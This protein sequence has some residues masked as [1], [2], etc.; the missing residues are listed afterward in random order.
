M[1]WPCLLHPGNSIGDRGALALISA[2]EGGTNGTANTELTTL[3]IAQ[4]N[5]LTQKAEDELRTRR[6]TLNRT[7]RAQGHE[8]LTMRL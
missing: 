5:K 1:T 8:D 6:D 3:R 7:R 2:L 4:N